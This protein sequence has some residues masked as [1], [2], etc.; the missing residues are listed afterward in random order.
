[1]NKL[2]DIGLNYKCGLCEHT[3]QEE[4]DLKAHILSL[5]R[6]LLSLCIR[7]DQRNVNFVENYFQQE[8]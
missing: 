2:E 8:V 4:V 5:H 1:M 3:F 6:H 7:K